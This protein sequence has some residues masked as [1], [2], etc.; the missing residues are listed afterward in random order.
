MTYLF[1]IVLNIKARWGLVGWGEGE[2]RVCS[3]T[4][5]SVCVDCLGFALSRLYGI[6]FSSTDFFLVVR[7]GELF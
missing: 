5:N 2:G 1:V 7:C 3:N 6:L 4:T